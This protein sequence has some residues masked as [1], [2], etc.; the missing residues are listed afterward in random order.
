MIKSVTAKYVKQHG[1]CTFASPDKTMAILTL[2]TDYGTAD[3]H[4][5]SVKG[6]VYKQLPDARIVDISHSVSPFDIAEAAFQLRQCY[7]HFAKGTVHLIGVNAQF[8]ENAPHRIAEYDGHFFI[9]ADAGVFSLIFD[10]EPD[11]VFDINLPSDSDIL[12]FPV[13]HILVNA[14]C[15]LM[16]GGTPEVI[17]KHVDSIHV[18]QRLR[19]L[20][21]ED[22]IRGHV[23]YV[24]RFGNLVTDIMNT[25]FKEVRK[26]RDFTIQLRTGKT[27]ISKISTHYN[28][29]A[30]GERVALF[31][32]NGNLEIA[33]NK[34]APGNGGGASQLFGLRKGDLILIIFHG[35]T[36]RQNDFS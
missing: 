4:V 2:T 9:A 12:T 31:N 21:E 14:A 11:A 29:V 18:A 6:A 34:G 19:P 28:E 26:E 25:L 35:R 7:A 3:H 5:A 1:F 24:D 8:S 10:R 32:T 33:I 36:H 15:H 30:E 17:S 16:R 13:L 23:I 20:L 27:R 22:A